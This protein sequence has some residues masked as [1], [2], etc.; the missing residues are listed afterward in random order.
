VFVIT[1]SL[2]VLNNFKNNEITAVPEEMQKAHFHYTSLINTELE[3]INAEVTPDTKKIIEDAMK[4][5][6]KLENDYVLLEKN[7]TENGNTK[8]ILY[9][10]ITNFQTR[11]NLL[12]EVL[13]K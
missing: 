11:T 6:T 8:Q 3:K 5:L 9:A 7:L 1:I 4:Q 2:T 12:Q 10:M 13:D